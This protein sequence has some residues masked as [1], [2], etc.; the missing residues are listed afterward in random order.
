MFNAD[1]LIFP[2]RG[3]VFIETMSETHLNV[4]VILLYCYKVSKSKYILKRRLPRCFP[5]IL[6]QYCTATTTLTGSFVRL[7]LCLCLCRGLLSPSPSDPHTE[8]LLPSPPCPPPAFLPSGGITPGRK[9]VL[10]RFCFCLE[11][12]S[13]SICFRT[14]STLRGSLFPSFPAPFCLLSTWCVLSQ[15][16][17]RFGPV[18]RR[19]AIVGVVVGFSHP[20]IDYHCWWSSSSS[21]SSQRE[22]SASGE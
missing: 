7:F 11:T 10:S 19:L 4:V 6:P 1:R 3:R 21:S 5:S 14:P 22:W 13:C 20:S 12:K 18:G 16:I 9:L 15:N 17:N 2:K 8:V